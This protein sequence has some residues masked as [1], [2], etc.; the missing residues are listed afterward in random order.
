MSLYSYLLAH[1]SGTA[2]NPFH[3]T[4]TL[5]ICKPAIRRTAQA[6][7]WIIATGRKNSITHRKLA[8]AMQVAEKIP[9]ENYFRDKR[10][11]AKQPNLKSK[12]WQDWLGDN[13]YQPNPDGTL[14]QLPGPEKRHT[15]EKDLSGKYVLIA[16]HF[17]Y[18][19]REAVPLPPSFEKLIHA[20]QGH[21]KE[22]PHD[23]VTKFLNWL[24]RTHKPGLQGNPLDAPI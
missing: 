23:L 15:P 2:P 24:D 13:I 7:D 22:V 21:R 14:T 11:R 8:Y 19:G 10:F 16:T 1:D 9:Q 17:F 18:F 20:N 5:A 6:G 12:N 4:C 3:G